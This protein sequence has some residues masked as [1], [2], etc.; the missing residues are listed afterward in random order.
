MD[1][2][3]GGLGVEDLSLM[4][5]DLMG[6]FLWDLIKEKD[7]ERILWVKEKHSCQRK[8]KTLFLKHVKY[9]RD[10]LFLKAVVKMDS[11]ERISAC[12]IN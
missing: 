10:M 2:D 4:K 11:G 3:G 8:T 5:L 1:E 12:K 9:I 6:K 7:T